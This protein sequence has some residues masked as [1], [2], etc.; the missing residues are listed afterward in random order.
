MYAVGLGQLEALPI[1]AALRGPLLPRPLNED[2]AHGLGRGGEEVAAIVELPVADQAQVSFVN[3]GGGVERLPR[4][5][6]RE[7][8]CGKATQLVVDQRQQLTGG[9]RIAGFESGQESGHVGHDVERTRSAGRCHAHVLLRLPVCDPD[10]NRLFL[11]PTTPSE[12]FCMPLRI[13]LL[14]LV[15]C[16]AAGARAFD[17]GN[18]DPPG[19]LGKT[20]VQKPESVL[21]RLV[22]CCEQ[23]RGRQIKIRDETV[24]LNETIAANDGKATADHKK[25]AVALADRQQELIRQAEKAIALVEKEG[26]MVESTELLKALQDYMEAVEKHLRQTDAGLRT[27]ADED[28]IVD[29]LELM[30]DALEKSR[31]RDK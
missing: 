1:A 25:A 5:L 28:R 12:G 13:S 8:G 16:T 24:K 14:V 11:R 4:L 30:V 22:R 29:T 23:L 27:K 10:Y 18:S 9:L 6:V 26:T 7:L 2:A 31:C 15:L 19:D 3:Q 20:V 21:V 17:A